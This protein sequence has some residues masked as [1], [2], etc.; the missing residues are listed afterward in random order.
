MKATPLINP[1]AQVLRDIVSHRR[2]ITDVFRKSQQSAQRAI[3]FESK[4][5]DL[6][7]LKTCL[8]AAEMM[9]RQDEAH[10]QH[11]FIPDQ[12]FA[13]PKN[14]YAPFDFSGKNQRGSLTVMHYPTH[15]LPYAKWVVEYLY[16]QRLRQKNSPR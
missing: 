7:F 4:A 14:E 11:I 13:T 5:A 10:Q 1:Q 16:Q 3:A 8:I 15:R 2:D 12:R 6:Y 9:R